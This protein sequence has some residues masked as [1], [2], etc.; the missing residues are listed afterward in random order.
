M[1]VVS[2]SSNAFLD[3]HLLGCPRGAKVSPAGCSKWTLQKQVVSRFNSVSTTHAT[4]VVRELS[5][6]QE[7]PLD[8]LKWADPTSCQPRKCWPLGVLEPG[9]IS[10][11]PSALPGHPPSREPTSTSRPLRPR[12]GMANQSSNAGAPWWD[13]AG[14]A[15]KFLLNVAIDK[16]AKVPFF[17]SLWG[18][19]IRSF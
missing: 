15:F 17:C 13:L 1:E 2:Q 4:G 9:A 11:L 5:A 6:S 18:H 12:G 8:P 10:C 19:C 16:N 3:R 7:G 14:S